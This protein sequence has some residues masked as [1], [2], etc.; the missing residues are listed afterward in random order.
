M[1]T[2][3]KIP[4]FFSSDFHIKMFR[5][6]AIFASQVSDLP[7]GGFSWGAGA[8]PENFSRGSP[9]LSKKKPITHTWPQGYKT[10]FVLVLRRVLLTR[11]L[12]FTEYDTKKLRL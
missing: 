1:Q 11:S 2:E 8:D 7:L 6:G 3:Q 9:T 5:V 12:Y 4:N 10:F